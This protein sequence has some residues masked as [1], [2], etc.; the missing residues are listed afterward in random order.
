[1]KRSTNSGSAVSPLSLENHSQWKPLYAG[2]MPTKILT[3]N[4]CS[5][6]SRTHALTIK[7]LQVAY[8][9]TRRT[10]FLNT[11]GPGTNT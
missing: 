7:T 8:S 11:C 4:A 5:S 6:L 10:P 3:I 9:E 1:M 2:S